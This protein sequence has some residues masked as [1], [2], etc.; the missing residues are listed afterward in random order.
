MG[1]GRQGS[2]GRKSLRPVP[3]KIV[4]HLKGLPNQ[5]QGSVGVNTC[6]YAPTQIILPSG[7]GSLLRHLVPHFSCQVSGYT[8]FTEQRNEVQDFSSKFTSNLRSL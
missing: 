4:N 8:Y 1:E 5:M 3:R 6:L 2:L 7:K